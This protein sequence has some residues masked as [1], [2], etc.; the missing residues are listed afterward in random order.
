MQD[1]PGRH[2]HRIASGCA[3]RVRIRCIGG[4]ITHTSTYMTKDQAERIAQTYEDILDALATPTFLR[5]VADQSDVRIRSDL[6]AT[7]EVVDGPIQSR[8]AYDGAPA[9]NGATVETR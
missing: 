9:L 4:G 8:P 1:I 6:V 7:I 3:Y 5:F 2:S